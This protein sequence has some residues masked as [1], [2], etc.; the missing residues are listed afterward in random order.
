MAQ[1][2]HRAVPL[3]R[4]HFKSKIKVQ[5]CA[6]LCRKKRRAAKQKCYPNYKTK[7]L[8]GC[9]EN[10][11]GNMAKNCWEICCKVDRAVPKICTM[12]HQHCF[13]RTVWKTCFKIWHKIDYSWIAKLI[14]LCQI[15]VKRLSRKVERAVSRI[16]RKEEICAI[17]CQKFLEEL[18]QKKNLFELCQTVDRA[19][20]K[21]YTELPQQFICANYV[22]ETM[23]QHLY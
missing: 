8:Q 22:F 10:L 4:K 17:L 2:Q 1:K 21:Y 20:P 12:L 7:L 13:W 11:L 16:V 19:V 14:E 15:I 9:A 5:N 23:A 18:C 3:K 6:G